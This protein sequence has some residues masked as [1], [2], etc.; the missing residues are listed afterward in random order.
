MNKKALEKIAIDYANEHGLIN[1]TSQILCQKAKISPSDFAK[2][3]ECGFYDFISRLTPK[4]KKEQIYKGEN[5]RQRM[6]GSTKKVQILMKAAE[7]AQ[8]IG[9]NNLRLTNVSKY[10]EVSPATVMYHFK[11]FETFKHE[12]AQYCVD[13]EILSVVAY[14]LCEGSLSSDDVTTALKKKAIA[15]LK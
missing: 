10:V 12:L 1:L 14:L 3:A 5:T 9:F 6:P 2:Y 11:R 13:N 4:L 8:E 15:S 7:L